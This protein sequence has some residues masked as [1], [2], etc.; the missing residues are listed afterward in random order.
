MSYQFKVGDKGKTRD[1]RWGYEVLAI[2]FGFK[3]KPVIIKLFEGTRR[4]LLAQRNID[5]TADAD[6]I[7]MGSD[8]MPPTKTVYLNVFTNGEVVSY[9]TAEKAITAATVNYGAAWKI[10]LT[11]M[12]LEIPQS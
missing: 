1:G 7:N 6:G 11:A 8:L 5:G 10:A 12:P 3:N 2:D 9:G 4:P